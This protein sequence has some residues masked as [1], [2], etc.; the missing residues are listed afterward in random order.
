MVLLTGDWGD[1]RSREGV[2]I[3]HLPP[4]VLQWRGA[5]S[6][7]RDRNKADD[8]CS[9]AAAA[10]FVLLHNASIVSVRAGGL[11]YKPV[12]SA[13]L[14]RWFAGSNPAG[15]AHRLQELLMKGVGRHV[16]VSMKAKS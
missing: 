5:E 9:C 6:G 1:L 12:I 3:A 2:R 10:D 8:C 14:A 15:R 7:L 11:Y 4:N 13:G 16:A